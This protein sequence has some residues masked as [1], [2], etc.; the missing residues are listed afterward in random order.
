MLR[1]RPERKRCFFEKKQQKTFLNLGRKSWAGCG[2]A[3]GPDLD[4]RAAL[5]SPALWDSCTG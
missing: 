3:K 1:I 2:L 4:G 5:R